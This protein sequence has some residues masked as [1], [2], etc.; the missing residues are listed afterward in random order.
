MVNEKQPL[1]KPARKGEVLASRMTRAERHLIEAAAV[2]TGM[3]LSDFLRSAAIG[4]A[5][6]AVATDPA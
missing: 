1:D 2:A 6:H 3:T 4:V 5:R